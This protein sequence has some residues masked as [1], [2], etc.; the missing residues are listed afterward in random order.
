VVTIYSSSLQRAY[1]QIL[2]DVC[3][4]KL[5]VVFAL[6]RAGLVGADGPAHRGTFD[7]S[8]LRSIPNMV[9][10]AP[11]DENELR[12]IGIR[13]SEERSTER[14]PKSAYAIVLAHS[15]QSGKR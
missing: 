4:Q 5:H 1:D 7:F 12:L 11:K 2:H 13:S 15:E 9:I 14:M 8:Y 3:L 10:M 6:D